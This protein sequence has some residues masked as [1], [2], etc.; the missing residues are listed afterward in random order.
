MKSPDSRASRRGEGAGI[1]A[2]MLYKLRWIT[3]N[4]LTKPEVR[5]PQ[6]ADRPGL[7]QSLYVLQQ[8]LN[9]ITVL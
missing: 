3:E 2:A 6:P 5:M 9:V 1:Y 8:S 7:V 4:Y